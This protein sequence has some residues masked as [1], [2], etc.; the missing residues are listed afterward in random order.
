MI[1]KSFNLNDIKKSNAIFFLIYGENE[2]QKDEIIKEIFLNNFKGE[3]IKYEENQILDNNDIFFEACLNE[4]LFEN[5]K[6]ILVN[7]VTIKIYEIIKKLLDNKVFNKKIILNSNILEKKSK[8]RKLFEEENKLVCV[9]VYQDNNASLFKIANNFFKTN[10]ISISSENINFIVDKSSGDRKNL[11]N[12]MNKILNFCFSKRKINNEELQKLINE[13]QDENY[14]ELV[15]NCLAKNYT[16]VNRIINNSIFNNSESIILIRSFLS[17]VKRL[18]EL[19]KLQSQIG[20][21][22]DTVNSYRPPIF[23]KDKEIVEKQ[24]KS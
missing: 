24:I 20:S 21:E 23:W 19:K 1:I 12:E 13:N 16:K 2:G 6:I 11:Y 17:R 14:F 7:R 9:A 15:D 22:K 3:I 8:L 4:S 10:N 18:I 5:E